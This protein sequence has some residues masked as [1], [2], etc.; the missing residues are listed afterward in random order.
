MNES[1]LPRERKLEAEPHGQ[2]STNATVADATP[3]ASTWRRLAALGRLVALLRPYRRRFALATVALLASSGTGLVYPQAVRWGVDAGLGAASREMLDLAVLALIGL[4]A[5]QSAMIW[6]RHYLMSW[7]GERAVAD[8]RKR[9][10]DRI[11]ALHPAWFFERPSGELVGRLASDVAVVEGVVGSELSMALRNGV[12]LVGGLV[13]LFI[14]DVELTLVML[15]IVPPL[16]VGVVVFGRRIRAMAAHVQDRLAEAS[17]R[18]QDSVVGIQTVQAF[19]QERQEADRY[20]A[21]VEGAFREAVRLATWRAAFMATASFAGLA[22]VALV[23][24]IGGRAVVDGELSGGDLTAFLLYTTIVAVSLGALADLWGSIQRAAGATGRLFA[25]VDAVPEIRD[26]EQAEPLPEGPLGLTYDG[27]RFRYPTRQE[28]EVLRGV[29]LEVAPGELCALVGP[30]GAGKTTLTALVPRFFDPSGGAVRLGGVDLRR[31]RLAEL[32]GALA[33]VPQEPVLLGET[34]FDAVSYG[35]PGASREDVEAACRE[36]N[37]HDF[38]RDLPEVYGTRVGEGGRQLSGGQ[39]QRL[40]IA[41]AL[42]RDPRVLILDEATSHLDAESEALVQDALDRLVRGRTTIVVAHRLSTVRRADRIVVV[43]QGR[44]AE[45]GTHDE[46]LAGDGLYHRLV[47][48]Q[49]L[50]DGANPRRAPFAGEVG[51]L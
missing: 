27:V 1:H 12:T 26:P 8:L 44:I 24:W 45:Q 10:F 33:L 9:V 4:F 2:A 5:F 42:L 25:I 48:H 40:A 30:S 28:H 18:V 6:A 38:I 3:R 21:G 39:R 13:L 41:R 11:L 34:V 32:R 7:L 23:V 15:C 46:L 51:T 22:A 43:D 49:L 50:D 31:L 16:A 17:S 35:V 37:A 19:G 29:D 36:A 14:E 47:A 20:G